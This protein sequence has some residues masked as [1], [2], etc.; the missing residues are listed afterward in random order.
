MDSNLFLCLFTLAQVAT[1][2][3]KAIATSNTDIIVN[4]VEILFIMDLDEWLF[5]GLEAWNEN[6]TKHASD[7][8]GASSNVVAEERGETEEMKEEIALQKVQIADQQKELV[9]QKDQMTRQNDQIAMLRETVQ[10]L[11][12]SIAAFSL[13]ESI[14]QCSVNEGLAPYSVE[15]EENT[16]LDAVAGEVETMHLL[17]DNNLSQRGQITA[18]QRTMP[19]NSEQENEESQA[20]AATSDC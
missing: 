14:P 20:G 5:A 19:G 18:S 8:E 12:A 1:V 10:K 11:Q 6:W 2:Y 16:C 3:N 4:S 7:S 15:S 13:S 17:N 9:L